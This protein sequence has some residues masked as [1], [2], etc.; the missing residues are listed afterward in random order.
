[1][2]AFLWWRARGLQGDP[3]AL[4]EEERRRAQRAEPL[5]LEELE[6]RLATAPR[7]FHVCVDCRVVIGRDEFTG[8]CPRCGSASPVMEVRSDEDARL[9]RSAVGL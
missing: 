1:M 5:A 9:A 3:S 6:S 7:P 2:G 8:R 4:R